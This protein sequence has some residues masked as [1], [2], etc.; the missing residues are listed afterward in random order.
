MLFVLM[1]FLMLC[2]LTFFCLW[3]SFLLFDH[4]PV[5]SWRFYRAF[6]LFGL[7]Y[8]ASFIAVLVSVRVVALGD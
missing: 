5:W 4:S 1:I 3:V 2:A 8:C 6:V 7:A